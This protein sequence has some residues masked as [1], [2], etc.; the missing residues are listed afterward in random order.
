M[1]EPKDIKNA[2]IS[3]INFFG[4]GRGT[5]T[6]TVSPPADFESAASTYSAI[7]A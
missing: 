7:P 3:G 5:R 4:T 2:A 6:L 1:K